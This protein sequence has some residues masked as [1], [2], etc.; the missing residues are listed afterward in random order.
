[1]RNAY[2]LLDFG[3][4][5]VKSNDRSNPYIQ[6]ASVTNVEQAYN[7]FVQVRLGGLDT[8][9]DAKWSLLPVD[10]MQHSPVSDEEKKKKYQEMVL[11]RWPYILTGCLVFVLLLIGLCIWR[12]CCRKGGS[13]KKSKVQILPFSAGKEAGESEAYLPL[14]EQN[15]SLN[16]SHS[17]NPQ[18]PGG[19]NYPN[20]TSRDSLVAAGNYPNSPSHDTFAA[21]GKYSPSP[22]YGNGGNRTPS[23]QPA[24]I[25]S[26]KYPPSPQ[27]ESHA[28]GGSP[29]SS[30]QPTYAAGGNYQHSPSH[31]NFV[32]AAGNYPSSPPQYASRATSGNYPRSPSH[33]TFAAAGNYQTS[34]H[35][36]YA[37]GSN[38]QTN[39]QGGGGGQ[40]PPSPSRDSF[41]AANYQNNGGYPPSGQGYTQHYP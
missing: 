41:A 19:G 23:P 24:Y 2:T 15:R 36:G 11:S 1:M 8:T 5:I 34:Q 22:Q 37:A 35:G 32:A 33:D 30:P 13:K 20:S 27:Y 28:A 38:Y 39:A 25:A 16:R 3:D 17:L 18:Y 6:L 21:S 4:W 9:S 29:M 31:D 12:C 14:N 40:Y 26:G 7:D 10:Q